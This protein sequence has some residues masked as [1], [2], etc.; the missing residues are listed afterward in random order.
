MTQ[1]RSYNFTSIIKIN[2]VIII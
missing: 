2:V 1:N